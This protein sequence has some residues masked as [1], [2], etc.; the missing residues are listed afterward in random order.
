MALEL[1]FTDDTGVVHNDAYFHVNDVIVENKVTAIIS[2]LIYVSE[3]SKNDG[4]NPI[5]NGLKVRYVLKDS[6]YTAYFSD[7]ALS[8]AGKSPQGSAYEYLKTLTTPFDFKN[9]STDV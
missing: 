3:A 9:N 6:D 5:N 4:K 2:V 7:T 8:V 1:T